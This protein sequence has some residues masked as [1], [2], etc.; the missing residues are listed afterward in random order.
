MKNMKIIGYSLFFVLIVLVFFKNLIFKPN[1]L[2]ASL[3][4]YLTNATATSAPF[5]LSSAATLGNADSTKYLFACVL[6]AYQRTIKYP[7]DGASMR[8]T[9][10]ERN[11]IE[12]INAELNVLEHRQS[13]W[14]FAKSESHWNMI[15][16]DKDSHLQIVDLSANSIPILLPANSDD[17]VAYDTA[18]MRKVALKEYPYGFGLELI[19]INNPRK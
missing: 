1:P 4:H 2:E 15:F 11:L 17:C 7:V 3:K 13:I 14:S 10:I 8:D 18:A 19:Q 9:K 16:V 6:G 5:L 12:K